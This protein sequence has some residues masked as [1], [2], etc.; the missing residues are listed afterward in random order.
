MT[1]HTTATAHRPA[2][3]PTQAEV[4]AWLD[5]HV[6]GRT[7]EQ[8][9]LVLAEEVGE[10]ARAVVKRAQGVRGSHA[11][12]TAALHDE[13]ADVLLTCLAIAATEGFDLH[14]AAARKW[15]QILRRDPAGHRPAPTDTDPEA[16]ETPAPPAGASGTGG[17]RGGW[18]AQVVAGL[19]RVFTAEL[20]ARIADS[21]AFG[22]LAYRL[23]E[24]VDEY[25]GT[26][27]DVLG[28]VGEADRRFA[29]RANDPAAFLAR[30]VA[31][32]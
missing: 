15:A 6:P 18:E 12:W 7:L 16:P 31:E 14:T 4:D 25:G 3:P 13:V 26:P 27:A 10:V 9:V 24:C 11:E 30:K 21:D 2:G 17:D 22:A 29:A 8:Q 1:E 32:L 20:A 5:Q 19:A 28:Q 23:G